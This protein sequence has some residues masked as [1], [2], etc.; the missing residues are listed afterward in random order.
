MLR[1]KENVL[2]MKRMTFRVLDTPF[3]LMEYLQGRIFLD[4]TLSDVPL[5]DRREI[6]M[7][8]IRTLAKLHSTNYEKVGLGDFGKP[9]I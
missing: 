1:G 6:Y 5:K 3:Y 2:K 7:E 8:M 9:G 4:P